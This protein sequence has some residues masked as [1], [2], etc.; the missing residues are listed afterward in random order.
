MA[1][2]GRR[3]QRRA[4]EKQR[5]RRGSQVVATQPQQEVIARPPSL[6]G[7]G[8]LHFE[9]EE[10]YSGPIP[11]AS[12]LAG[13]ED[14]QTGLAERIVGMAER[15]SRHRQRLETL[16]VAWEHLHVTLGQVSALVV[17]LF[18][19]WIAWD[20]GQD[21]EPLLAAFIGAVDIVALVSVFIY[22][23]RAEQQQP[24]TA[25]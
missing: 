13:Y 12:E 18:F 15:Q 6:P 3:S 25:P 23:K 5:Q 14:V 4:A 7:P 20:L 19:G 22:G 21:G 17:A 8:Q 16:D 1:S 24:P 9:V 10:H 2:S 11:M